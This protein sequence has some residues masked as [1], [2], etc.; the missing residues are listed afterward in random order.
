VGPGD[1]AREVDGLRRALGAAALRRIPPHVTLVP[2]V[3]VAEGELDDAV[4]LVRR[5]AADASSIRLELGPPATFWPDTPVVYL[6]V[7]G[8]L[9]AVAS[10]R[11][12]LLNGPLHRE[13]RRAFVPHVT[14]DQH[15]DPSRIPAALQALADYRAAV[16]V[17]LVTT[18]QLDESVDPRVWRPIA[19]ATLGRPRVV[20]TGGL[21][22]ELAVS[23][24]LDPAGERFQESE[25]ASYALDA[26]GDASRDEPFAI[27]ARIGGEIV[28][29]ATG[30]L[31]ADYCRLANLIV[32]AH[33]RNH[34]VGSHLLRTT[35]Q[36]ARE[37]G[38]PAVRLETRAGGAAEALYRSRGYEVVGLLPRFRRG[39][40][41][42][43]MERA[44]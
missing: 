41:F 24:A 6:E 7:G 29:T 23:T 14:L 22:V 4:E 19:A 5:V 26:Y 2:P 9:E 11:E 16:T 13:D 20:G 39:H 8:D 38:C 1:V 21:E 30:Q 42:V 28:G 15:I 43:L 35:E 27:T 12:S 10:L 36:L 34:G 25:W 17:E 31:R 18:L 44:V 33:W 37:H 40:D 32:V 3:N